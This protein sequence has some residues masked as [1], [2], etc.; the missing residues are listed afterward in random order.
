MGAYYVGLDV[1]SRETVFAIQDPTGAVI[2]RGALPTTAEAFARMCHQY[3][4]PAG[5]PVALETGTS[6]F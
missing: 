2:G 1:H 4:L 5:T 3:Q 6:A